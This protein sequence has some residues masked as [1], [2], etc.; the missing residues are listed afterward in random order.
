M[1]KLRL[2][3]NVKNIRKILFLY[4]TAR[5]RFR[6]RFRIFFAEPEPEP[7][8]QKNAEPCGTGTGTTSLLCSYDFT[9]REVL[10][11]PGQIQVEYPN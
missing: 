6:I 3:K 2:G 10:I 5:F 7:E 1:N 9:Y 11:H 4:R 8:G